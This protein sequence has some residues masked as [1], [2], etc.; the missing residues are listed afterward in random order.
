MDDTVGLAG[1]GPDDTF[2]WDKVE[3]GLTGL[4]REAT[5]TEASSSDRIPGIGTPREFDDSAGPPLPRA[6]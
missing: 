5:L 1:V 4:V 6:T 2:R 3:M